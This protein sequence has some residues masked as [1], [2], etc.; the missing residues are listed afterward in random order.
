MHEVEETGMYHSVSKE[1]M[2]QDICTILRILKHMVSLSS[3]KSCNPPRKAKQM[4]AVAMLNTTAT[5]Q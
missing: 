1:V 3:M 5:V 2:T 4:N